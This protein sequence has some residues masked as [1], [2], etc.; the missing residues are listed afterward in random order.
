MVNLFADMGVSAGTLQSE[1]IQT[2][3]SDDLSP[4]RASFGRREYAAIDSAR[5]TELPPAK[6][7]VAFPPAFP[8]LLAAEHS[9]RIELMTS[10]AVAF[11]RS[12]MILANLGTHCGYCIFDDVGRIPL[13]VTPAYISREGSQQFAAVYRMRHLRVKLHTEHAPFRVFHCRHRRTRGTCSDNK[14]FRNLRNLVPMAHPD[15]G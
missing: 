8:L 6:L 15:I 13:P 9:E 7:R 14:P 10:I 5:D 12:P 4:A 3:P 11:A 2:G 1:L